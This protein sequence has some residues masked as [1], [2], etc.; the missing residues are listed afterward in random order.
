MGHLKYG[1][2]PEVFEIEDRALAHLKVIV[3]TKLRRG[4]NFPFSMRFGAD[5]GSGRETIWIHTAAQLSFEFNGSR[6]PTL[7]KDWLE[8]LMLTAN[9]NEGLRI[10]PEP[11][12]GAPV[13]DVLT[14]TKVR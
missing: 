7:N 9:S 1:S 12:E 6:P 2:P 10:L 4:E 3:L 13:T 14:V 8:A 11:D 5:V